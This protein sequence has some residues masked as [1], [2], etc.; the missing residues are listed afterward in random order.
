MAVNEKKKDGLFARLGAALFI[1]TAL[2][3]LAIAIANHLTNFFF[4][5]ANHRYLILSLV[6]LFSVLVFVFLL[7]TFKHKRSLFDCIETGNRVIMAFAT[8]LITGIILTTGVIPPAR[9]PISHT[10][11]IQALPA[12]GRVDST[13][14]VPVSY[15]HLTL[16]T[17]LRV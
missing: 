10:L 6:L 17:I 3:C 16:P 12:E 14:S 4:L 5:P 13:I 9:I 7:I 11:E 1:S 15:T 8:L 2:I